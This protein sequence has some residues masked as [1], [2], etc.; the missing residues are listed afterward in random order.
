MVERASAGPD[1][2]PAEA[3]KP[4]IWWG[5]SPKPN[6]RGVAPGWLDSDFITCLREHYQVKITDL[7]GIR[8]AEGQFFPAKRYLFS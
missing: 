8:L 3:A 6:T 4:E 2:P 5:N 1:A 7:E